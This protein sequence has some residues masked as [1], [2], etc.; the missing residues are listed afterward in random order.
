MKIKCA[1]IP[2]LKGTRVVNNT[3]L[4]K[5]FLLKKNM[6]INSIK[7]YLS[8]NE[9]IN[10]VYQKIIIDKLTDLEPHRC[11]YPNWTTNEIEGL[12]RLIRQRFIKKNDSH[13][14]QLLELAS[15]LVKSHPKESIILT[16]TE[17][18]ILFCFIDVDYIEHFSEKCSHL[19]AMEEGMQYWDKKV[20]LK[21]FMEI[22][23][24]A[25]DFPKNQDDEYGSD[26]YRTFKILSELTKEQKII[27]FLNSYS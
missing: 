24:V 17:E 21:L 20:L 25:M 12:Y 3:K 5:F 27:D 16:E 2:Y 18:N 10:P 11:D 26:F 13:D 22:K 14:C 15:Q 6:D 19:R 9:P 7:S 8:K 4:R 23:L 1:H